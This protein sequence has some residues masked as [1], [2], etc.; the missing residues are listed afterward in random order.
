[1]I[2]AD[3]DLVQALTESQRLGMLGA[4]PIPDVIA[5]S[6]A[7]V[8]ALDGVGGLVI[9]VGTG[10]GVPGLVIAARRPDLRLVLIDR[11][12]T[13][14]DHVRRL[15]SR[16]GWDKRVTVWTGDAAQATEFRQTAAAVVARG[17]GPPRSLLPV[18]ALLSTANG[19]LI[20]S[21]PPSR[22]GRWS[23]D[24]LA[25]HGYQ[26]EA[27]AIGAVTLITRGGASPSSCST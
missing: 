22:S 5:H 1:M 26:P 9:D 27:Q 11:R 19:V 18:A 10:G 6:E 17:F 25:R 13:R 8:A 20:V 7:F 15:L 4:K 14:T 16:L 12:Q 21:D 24:L 3:T 23:P 2:D